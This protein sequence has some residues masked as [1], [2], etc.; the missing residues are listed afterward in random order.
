VEQSPIL[1]HRKFPVTVRRPASIGDF[2]FGGF[3]SV[4][5]QNELS[6]DDTTVLADLLALLEQIQSSRK[7]SAGS[8]QNIYCG[9]QFSVYRIDD[10]ASRLRKYLVKRLS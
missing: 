7:G 2:N 4:N 5:N 1:A 10:L 3:V 8:Y 6:D 9:M